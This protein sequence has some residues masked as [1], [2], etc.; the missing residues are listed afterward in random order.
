MGGSEIPQGGS[1][2]E[3]AAQDACPREGAS[4]GSPAPAT[5]FLEEADAPQ[6]SARVASFE[7]WQ[8]GINTDTRHD[9][10]ALCFQA[11]R[12]APR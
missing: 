8:T 12:D 2:G 9:C 5:A 10:I 7:P 3:R 1:R 4:M 6:R 11:T